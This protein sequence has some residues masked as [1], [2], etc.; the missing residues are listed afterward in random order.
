[1]MILYQ[2]KYQGCNSEDARASGDGWLIGW[3][4][5]SFKDN[6]K[7]KK[8]IT[9]PSQKIVPVAVCERGAREPGNKKWKKTKKITD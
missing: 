1:M 8:L 9:N 3:M 7:K 2:G 6:W 4:R 5:V